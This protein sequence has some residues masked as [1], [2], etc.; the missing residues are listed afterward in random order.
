MLM[1]FKVRPNI[2]IALILVGALGLAI[3]FIGLKMD[4]NEAIIAAA[5]IGAIVAITNLAGKILEDD[6]DDEN[7]DTEEKSIKKAWNDFVGRIRPNIILAMFLVA[8]LGLVI[9]YLGSQWKSAS[10]NVGN[11]AIVAAAG[12]GAII[13][14]ANLAGKILEKEFTRETTGNVKKFITKIRPNILIAM[15]L[16]GGLGIGIGFIG[17][18]MTEEGLVTAAGVGAIVAI[19]NLAGK[20]LEREAIDI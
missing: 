19:T 13:A 3:S 15:I 4:K 7:Y 12:V 10:G 2:L 16:V 11:E 17:F 9:S 14:I 18:R 1:I 8:I 20:I 5:G 6:F